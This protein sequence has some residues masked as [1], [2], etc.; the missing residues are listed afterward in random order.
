MNYIPQFPYEMEH[1]GLPRQARD[2]HR[3]SSKK[4]GRLVSRSEGYQTSE[5]VIAILGSEDW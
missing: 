3:E 2:K 1:A 4:E 5:H